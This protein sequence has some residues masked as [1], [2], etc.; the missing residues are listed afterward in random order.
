[1]FLLQL[2]AFPL[3]FAELRLQLRPPFRLLPLHRPDDFG[4]E[5]GVLANGAN[6]LHDRRLESSRRDVRP[7]ARRRAFLQDAEALVVEV[8]AVALLRVPDGHRRPAG[9]A[10]GE[11]AKKR[12]L[13]RAPPRPP[14]ASAFRDHALH[15]VPG[16]LIDDRLVGA[17]VL[18]AGDDGSAA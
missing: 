14:V 18:L 15:L 3:G 17:G 13:L 10:A 5:L 7:G 2:L 4:E 6:L 8:L 16:G 11:A 9:P 1:M 12:L